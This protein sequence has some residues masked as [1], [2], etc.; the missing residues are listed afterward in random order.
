MNICADI[1]S[2]QD[3]HFVIF[4]LLYE[5]DKIIIF[6]QYS[7]IHWEQES[8]VGCYLDVRFN[9]WQHRL[10]NLG[11]LIVASEIIKKYFPVMHRQTLI[12]KSTSEHI[13]I[14]V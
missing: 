10:D 9:S 13:Q 4:W 1:S 11:Y 12:N 8:N 14:V 7:L 3:C 6:N 5:R 2:E